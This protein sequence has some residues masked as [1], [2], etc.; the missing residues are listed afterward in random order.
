MSQKVREMNGK[1][2]ITTDA[3]C[4]ILGISRV[5]I[6]K[7]ADDGCPKEAR[8]WW[9][10]AD[11]LRWRGLVGNSGI[12]TSNKAKE[13]TLNEKKMHFEVLLKEAQAEMA[14]IKNDIAKGNYIKRDE[15]VSTLSRYHTV[16]KRSLISLGKKVS[17][18]VG[19]FVD[20]LTARRI[21]NQIDEIIY[22]A[23]EQL[24][25]EGIYA[26]PKQKTVKG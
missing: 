19:V 7:W 5:A 1:I 6:K 23:L 11:V 25:V 10:I 15:I 4:E 12:K 9:C 22:D 2:L 26:A 24:A 18:E 21:E 3:L 17:S 16:L 20:S 13:L 14:E 8:G